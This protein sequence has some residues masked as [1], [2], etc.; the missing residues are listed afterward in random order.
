MTKVKKIQIFKDSKGEARVR[1]VFENGKKTNVTEGYKNT[2]YAEKLAQDLRK[3]LHLKKA[4]EDLR[5]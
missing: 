2:T 3:Q 4:V 5:K 1:M